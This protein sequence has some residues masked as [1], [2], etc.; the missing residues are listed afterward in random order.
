V[1]VRDGVPLW[2]WLI[3]VLC[4]AAVPIGAASATGV[5]SA[6]ALSPTT[7]QAT[8]DDLGPLPGTSS[9]SFTL[10]LGARHQAQLQTLV[11]A[12]TKVSSAAW[13]AMYG[14]DRPQLPVHA[15]YFRARDCRRPGYQ[16]IP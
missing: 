11:S 8:A 4:L 9:V 13:N 14:P 15:P 12:G 3:A 7:A 16:V 2:G 10:D 1:R 6:A 5:A